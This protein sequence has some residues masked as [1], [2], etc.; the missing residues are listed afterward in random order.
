MTKNRPIIN[1]ATEKKKITYKH[2]SPVEEMLLVKELYK[3]GY[4]KKLE[5]GGCEKL[6]KHFDNKWTVSQ[7]HSKI[8]LLRKTGNILK[9][10][11]AMEKTGGFEKLDKN[12]LLDD[13]EIYLN[14]LAEGITGIK[15]EV[16]RAIYDLGDAT[17]SNI[18]K[19][20]KTTRAN[21]GYHF[22]DLEQKKKLIMI[23]REGKENSYTLTNE[24]VYVAKKLFDHLPKEEKEEPVKIEKKLKKELEELPIEK[25]TNY[26]TVVFKDF[27]IKLNLSKLKAIF[28]GSV[29]IK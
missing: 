1:L 19:A 28:N 29:E 15:K 13:T 7:L 14:N 27:S 17:T 2:W 12:M 22:R 3:R 21:L 16:L 26:K 6:A 24:G 9:I 10:L 11:K 18:I 23:Y 20:A 4:I 25:E 5:F 8:Y